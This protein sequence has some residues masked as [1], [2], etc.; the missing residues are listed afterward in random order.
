MMNREI[1]I[2]KKNKIRPRKELELIQKSILKK[3]TRKLEETTINAEVQ[4]PQ[5]I[6]EAN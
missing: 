6:L 4:M 3:T 1:T 5:K 2:I